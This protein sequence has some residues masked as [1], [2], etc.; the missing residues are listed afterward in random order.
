MSLLEEPT[1]H[2]HGRFAG[3]L[4]AAALVVVTFLAAGAAAYY[5]FSQPA[6]PERAIAEREAPPARRP[7]A[8]E[9]ESPRVA[10]AVPARPPEAEPEA[11]PEPEPSVPAAARAVLRVTSDVEG[12]SVFVDRRFVGTTP[13][14]GTDIAP[15]PHRINVSAAGYDS[16]SEDVEISGDRVEVDVRFTRVRLD[17]SVP[18][19]HKHRMGSCEG[20]L[21]ATLDGVRYETSDDDAFALPFAQIETF[22]IDYLDHTLTI[23]ARGGRAYNFTDRTANA[24]A[25]F[26]FHREVQKARER[27]AAHR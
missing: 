24:D 22:T 25:L 6:A 13:F 7:R 1:P 23:K 18:V 14:E 26:V 3:R 11:T 9:P 12:A 20:R 8:A 5:Y 21:V 19:V 15:G 4:I 27:L 2:S 16:Y 10:E 17:E